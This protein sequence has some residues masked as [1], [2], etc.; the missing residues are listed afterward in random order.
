MFGLGMSLNL[1]RFLGRRCDTGKLQSREQQWIFELN[2]LIAN[3]YLYWKYEWDNV[4]NLYVPVKLTVKQ[5]QKPLVTFLSTGCSQQ[6][7]R[8]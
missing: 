2:N 7:S 8:Q 1:W 6:E 5:A 3:W 4:V